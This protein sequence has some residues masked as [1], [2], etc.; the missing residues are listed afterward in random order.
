MARDP[1]GEKRPTCSRQ[2]DADDGKNAAA[3]ALGRMGGKAQ[4]EGHVRQA[5]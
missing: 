1:K 5:A 2:R 3:L 4:A